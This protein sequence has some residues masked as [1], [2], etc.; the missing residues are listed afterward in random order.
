MWAK[1]WAIRLVFGFAAWSGKIFLDFFGGA[2]FLPH[3][4][5]GCQESIFADKSRWEKKKESEKEVGPAKPRHCMI[6]I[7]WCPFY[8][9]P[10][11]GWH[12]FTNVFEHHEEVAS[13]RWFV[14]KQ[15][16]KPAGHRIQIF[17]VHYLLP[18]S[19]S[20]GYTSSTARLHSSWHRIFGRPCLRW[21][22]WAAHFMAV[23]YIGCLTAAG[24][25][26]VW[27]LF[28]SSV[29]VC[30]YPLNLCRGMAPTARFSANGPSKS[31]QQFWTRSSVSWMAATFWREAMLPKALWLACPAM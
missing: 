3:W 29:N 31:L 12:P 25:L 15:Q 20:S 19:I 28:V 23:L 27:K 13:R 14:S 8:V 21:T 17:F 26:C 18:C 16:F 9:W 6:A 2:I 30:K 10:I 24:Q 1:V 5:G 7:A 11:S 4:W 22:A